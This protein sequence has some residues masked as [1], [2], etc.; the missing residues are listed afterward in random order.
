MSNTRRQILIDLLWVLLMLA[1]M[2]ALYWCSGCIAPALHV[3]DG[4]AAAQGGV[5]AKVT[6]SMPVAV[7]AQDIAAVKAEV[8]AEVNAVKTET[9]TTVEAARDAIVRNGVKDSTLVYCFLGYFAI[10]KLTNVFHDWIKS[11]RVKRS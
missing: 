7:S 2:G 11:R 10:S 9:K 8:K 3:T 4:G 1:G 5:V 6:T